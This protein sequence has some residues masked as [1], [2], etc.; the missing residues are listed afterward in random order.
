MKFIF[1]SKSAYLAFLSH[2]T[3]LI[4]KVSLIFFLKLR[5]RGLGYR[6]RRYTSF[7]YRFYFTRTNYIYFHVPAA[8]VVKK[9]KKRIL[10]LSTNY[11]LVRLVFANLMLL[12]KVGPYNRR[13]FAYPRQII[14]LKPVKKL[15]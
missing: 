15:A 11:H 9:R 8:L 10:L 4:N 12:H 13:G 6:I 1:I 14:F 7:F 5:L 3:N 2:F